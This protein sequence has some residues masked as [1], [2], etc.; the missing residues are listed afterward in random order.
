M[1][2][3]VLDT[4]TTGLKHSEGDRV[5]EIGCVE[6][7][8]RV[9][10]GK[11]FHRYLK[12]DKE[13]SPGALNVHGLTKDFLSDK[14][15]FSEIVSEFMQF[16]GNDPL[17][18]HNAKFDIGFLNNELE[19]INKAT[20]SNQIVDSLVSARKKYPGQKNSLDALCKRYN[21]DSSKRVKHGA[22]LDAELLADVY[23]EL[24]GGSQ[25]TFDLV[26]EQKLEQKDISKVKF[27][28]R[29]YK[30][31]LQEENDHAKMLQKI[32]NNLWK[33]D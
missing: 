20:L 19:L 33:N 12:V 30:T 1:R 24:T 10:S 8:N 14:P 5:I 22:L 23:L 2:E 31:S 7:I 21:I 32:P 13:S 6:I 27:P 17:V 29:E 15:E 18:I 25:I 3:I 4:E 28:L 9:R 11:Y 26:K 16:I